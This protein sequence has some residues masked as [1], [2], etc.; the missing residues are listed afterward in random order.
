[1]AHSSSQEQ[2]VMVGIVLRSPS[3]PSAMLVP[4]TEKHFTGASPRSFS[5]R[6]KYTWMNFLASC[7]ICSKLHWVFYFKGR[8]E[9]FLKYPGAPCKVTLFP[10]RQ[11]LCISCSSVGMQLRHVC[12]AVPQGRGRLSAAAVHSGRFWFWGWGLGLIP[13]C[14]LP[15]AD[16]SC[17]RKG[18]GAGCCTMGGARQAA[19]GAGCCAALKRWARTEVKPQLSQ[20]C[21]AFPFEALIKIEVTSYSKPVEPVGRIR[22]PGSSL[23]HALF[24]ATNAMPIA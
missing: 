3:P 10:W 16:G 24:V 1:M 11:S 4:F 5:L 23:H 15:C 19:R 13:W 17:A 12:V 8:S 22:A 6:E 9:P 2:W 14:R 21:A 7:A 18:K 20:V